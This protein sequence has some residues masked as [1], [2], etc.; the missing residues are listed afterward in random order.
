[1]KDIMNLCLFIG[2]LTEKGYRKRIQKVELEIVEQ[3]FLDG[4]F[5]N[6]TI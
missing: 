6:L 1:M 3:E 2:D 4:K 5:L